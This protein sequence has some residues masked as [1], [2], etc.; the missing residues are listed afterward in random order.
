MS[1]I[2]QNVK[3]VRSRLM[4][5]LLLDRLTLGVFVGSAAFAVVLLVERT[6]GLGVP[7]MIAAIAAAAI[8]IIVGV[9][10]AIRDQVSMV[11]AAIVIDRAAG[12]KERLST[13]VAMRASDD[14]FAAATVHD[15]EQLAARVHVPSHIRYVAPRYLPASAGAIAIAALLFFLM[16]AFNLLAAEPEQPDDQPDPTIVAVQREEIELAIDQKLDS[17]RKRIEQA[18]ATTEN[19]LTDHLDELE[20]PKDPGMTPEDIRREVVKKVERVS[21]RIEQKL[22]GD[23]LKAFEELKRDLSKLETPEGDNAAS[24]FAEALKS[25]DGKQAK[26][27]LAKLK[28]EL[29]AAA[30]KGDAEAKK[31][32]A[33]LEKSLDDL[34][35]QVDKLADTS[36]MQKELQNKA[37]L[38]EEQAKQLL[39]KLQNMDPEQL[40][41]AVNKALQESGMSQ[42]QLQQ[43]AQKLAQQQQARQLAQQMAQQMQQAAQACKQCQKGGEAGQQG[44]QGAASAMQGLQD[45]MQQMEA[46]QQMAGELQAQLADLQD[47]KQGTC[48][49]GGQ[50]Q[51]P[52]RKDMDQNQIGG[53]GPQVGLGYGAQTGKQRAAHGMDP[54]KAKTIT[55]RGEIIAQMEFDGPQVK[56]EASEAISDA[57][58]AALRDAQDAVDNNRVPRQYQRVFQSY[59]DQLAGLKPREAGDGDAPAAEGAAETGEASGESTSESAPRDNG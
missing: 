51:A 16:P 3:Q 24:Q 5:N 1:I 10:G 31:Q 44:Q 13:A 55:Q 40:K 34:S 28:N 8:A 50:L 25:G 42:E 7:L 6:L 57:V 20:I 33:E 45:Q 12:L 38:T 21:E 41:Q 56:G 27:A 9:V 47:L 39:N 4:L 59:F 29:K 37:G 22:E 17:V 11:G 23:E 43:L 36:K 35:K 32:L 49:G 46:A 52:Q 18:G 2:D 14:P 53:Q 30:E 15:A 26:E 48:E 58:N 54:T 19:K